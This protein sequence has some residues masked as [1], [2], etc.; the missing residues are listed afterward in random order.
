M[1]LDP[2]TPKLSVRSFCFYI[3]FLILIGCT[4]HV[5]VDNDSNSPIKNNDDNIA[6][7]EL[8]NGHHELKEEIKKMNIEINRLN[9][10]SGMEFA[11]FNSEIN[12]MSDVLECYRLR[13]QLIDVWNEHHPIEGKCNS[14][15]NGMCGTTGL[16]PNTIRDYSVKLNVFKKTLYMR[17]EYI[18]KRYNDLGQAPIPNVDS[19]WIKEGK[20]KEAYIAARQRADEM[21]KK[22]ITHCSPIIWNRSVGFDMLINDDG[23][24]IDDN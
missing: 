15:N 21:T 12:K 11:R 22:F 14:L 17:P 23:D 10:L 9:D 2:P 7:S 1:P 4:T 3:I 20:D 16:K 18:V 5:D 24:L 13:D 19:F 8:I 6:M